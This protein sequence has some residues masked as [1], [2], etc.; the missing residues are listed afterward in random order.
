MRQETREL[1]SSSDSG[2]NPNTI[3]KIIGQ[4]LTPQAV[5]TQA[6]HFITW[7]SQPRWQLPLLAF[8]AVF[9]G[10]NK[11]YPKHRDLAK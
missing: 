9:I 4:E 6:S 3:G 1:L 10:E 11:A 5:H 2:N 8:Q 7:N